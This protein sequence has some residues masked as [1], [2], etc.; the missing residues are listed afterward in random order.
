MKLTE[1]QQKILKKWIEDG[2]GLSE[3]QKRL[4]SE[5]NLNV[6]YMDVRFLLIDL[7]LKVKEA[8]ATVPEKPKPT[9][10]LKPE[11]PEEDEEPTDIKNNAPAPAGLGNVK[12]TVDRIVQ[13]GSIASGSVTFSDNVS[14]KWGLD[15]MGRLGLQTSKEGY[16]PS[17]TDIRAFQQELKKI[18]EK[19]GY[20]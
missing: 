2:A 5:L 14:G 7:G 11:E 8:P 12:V 16:R 18:L 17:Q 13:P 19:Q 20:G 6:T 3:I 4:R 1:E 9:D 10:N 15:Q